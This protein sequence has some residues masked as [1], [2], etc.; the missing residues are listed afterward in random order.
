[1]KLPDYIQHK[2]ISHEEIPAIFTNS[3]RESHQLVFTNGCFDI[4]HRGHIHMLTSAKELGDKLVIGLNTDASVRI[5][6]GK[7]R[8]VKD[9]ITR[10]EILASLTVV[11]FVILF[12][13]ETPHE[14]ILQVKP[15]VL[16]KGGD[17]KAENIVGHDI[18][19][20]YGGKICTI[21]FLK[22]FSTSSLIHKIEN[23]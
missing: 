20:S 8:P 19:S 10:A 2:I 6:K 17:Y 23:R 14:L 11:D 18:V 22:G 12:N 3:F 15:D 1:M 9:E 4:L 5:L 13:D 7:N 16:V 21:P